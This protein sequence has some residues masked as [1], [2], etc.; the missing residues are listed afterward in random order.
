MRYAERFDVGSSE[1]EVV[2]MKKLLIAVIAFILAI[3]VIFFLGIFIF[4]FQETD[5]MKPFIIAAVIVVIF[6]LMAAVF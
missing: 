5:L 3:V 6:I 1:S 2:A 4:V